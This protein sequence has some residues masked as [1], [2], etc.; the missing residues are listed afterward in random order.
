MVLDLG[1]GPGRAHEAAVGIPLILSTA[2]AAVSRDPKSKPRCGIMKVRTRGVRQEG[3]FVIDCGRS[4]MVS[5]RT[6]TPKRKL[7]PGVR[8]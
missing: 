3:K 4:V 6:H 8:P 2:C 1:S 7:Y 5:K